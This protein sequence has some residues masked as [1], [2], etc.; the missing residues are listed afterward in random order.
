MGIPSRGCPPR[1]T[2]LRRLGDLVVVR[3][4]LHMEEM[5]EERYDILLSKEL[6]LC[7]WR[8]VFSE[9]LKL[10][11]WRLVFSKELKLCICT[12]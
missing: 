11:I 5:L 6:K 8:L 3:T 10:C 12:M 1:Y 2:S 4:D 9:E 7:T